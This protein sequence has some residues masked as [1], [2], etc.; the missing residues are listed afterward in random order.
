MVFVGTDRNKPALRTE[1]LL[2]AHVIKD[3]IKNELQQPA[4]SETVQ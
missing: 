4:A 3:I 2:P 1:G